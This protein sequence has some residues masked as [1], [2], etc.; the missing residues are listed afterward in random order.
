MSARSCSRDNTKLDESLNDVGLAAV[1]AMPVEDP[2][3]AGQKWSWR[4]GDDE[5]RC[6]DVLAGGSSAHP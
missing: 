2:A 4:D 1:Y 5:F 3:P 6:G